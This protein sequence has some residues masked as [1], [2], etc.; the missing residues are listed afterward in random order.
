MNEELQERVLA[1]LLRFPSAFESAAS[2]LKATWWSEGFLRDAYNLI[3]IIWKK[4]RTVP[5][6]RE[7]RSFVKRMAA[8]FP[9]LEREEY[10][11]RADAL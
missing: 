2:H 5:G 1:Y 9:A 8:T 7:L 10:L 3:R 4:T 11:D 6:K